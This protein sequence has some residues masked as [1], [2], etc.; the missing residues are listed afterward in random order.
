M[1][2]LEMLLRDV[3]PAPDPA[4]AAKLDARVAARF[5]KP[6]PAWKKPLI[7]FREHFIAFGAVA[8][9]GCA[10]LAL[11]IAGRRIPTAATTP[12]RAVAPCP[13]REPPRKSAEDSAGGAPPPRNRPR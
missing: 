9:V 4:W 10:I 5:P 8:T 12:G 1:P 7:A 6:T 11:V 13:C 3:R 2:D